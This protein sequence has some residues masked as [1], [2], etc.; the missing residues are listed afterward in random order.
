MV[1]HMKTSATTT[2]IDSNMLDELLENQKKLDDIFSS[3]FDDEDPFLTSAKHRTLE[4]NT[5]R[6]QAYGSNEDLS[7]ST[8]DDFFIQQKD[9][10]IAHFIMP[11]ALEIAVIYCSIMY[12]S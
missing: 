9:R 3:I 11:V 7:F 5:Q 4:S 10:N 12:F 6:S 1:N 2:T 8:K